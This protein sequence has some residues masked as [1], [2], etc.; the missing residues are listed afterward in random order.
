[1]STVCGI[2]K[3]IIKPDI[4]ILLNVPEVTAST[5][6][7]KQETLQSFLDMKVEKPKET[8]REKV[9]KGFLELADNPPYQKKWFV[10]DGTKPV[11]EVF[12][13]IWS[14]VQERLA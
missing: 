3:P 8:L 5:R 11:E 2:E 4:I 7:T 9:R 10:V 6:G 13:D 14:I 1:M 12:T